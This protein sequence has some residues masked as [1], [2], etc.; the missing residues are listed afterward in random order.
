MN[1]N[2]RIRQ[3]QDPTKIN[4]HETWELK[5]WTQHLGVSEQK[6][7]DAVKAVG[8]SVTAVKRHLGK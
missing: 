2:L 1:D 8:V 4:V 6:L 7:K 5:Y 3:P